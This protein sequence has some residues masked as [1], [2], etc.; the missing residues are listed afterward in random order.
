[1]AHEFGFEC[2]YLDK[3]LLDSIA[4]VDKA[5]LLS[6]D[7][8][9][10]SMEA[11]NYFWSVNHNFYFSCSYISMLMQIAEHLIS[12]YIGHLDVLLCTE[13]LNRKISKKTFDE[14]VKMS[15][16]QTFDLKIKSKWRDELIFVAKSWRTL[17][18][19]IQKNK[20]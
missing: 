3:N 4:L 15:L 14:K 20:K 5:D 8:K 19:N 12:Q 18:R 2:G 16:D 6:D 10:Y 11:D 7:A 13:A 17:Q 9:I 1:M